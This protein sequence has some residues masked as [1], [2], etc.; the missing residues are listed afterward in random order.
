M[1]LP[2]YVTV[3][4]GPFNGPDDSDSAMQWVDITAWV[5]T[6]GGV[7]IPTSSFGRQ[8]DLSTVDPGQFT[9]ALNNQDHRFTPGNPSSPYSPGWRSGMRLRMVETVGFR[10]YLLAD[11]NMLQPAVTIQ[12]PDRFQ[13]VTV[14]AQDRIGR[15]QNSRKF[16]STLAEYIL[17]NGGS[18]LKAYYPCN[19]TGASFTDVSGNDQPPLRFRSDLP[20]GIATTSG[21]SL[22]LGG[23][24]APVFNDDGATI[25]MQA[26][27]G[28]TVAGLNGYS[29]VPDVAGLAYSLSIPA[30]QVMTLVTWFNASP[31]P[32]PRDM[33]AAG[34]YIKTT[35]EQI[36]TFLSSTNGLSV[37][38]SGS[39]SVGLTAIG[40]VPL[41]GWL[42][43]TIRY[44][45]SPQ[46][47]EA[48]I[49]TYR[50]AL[51]PSGSPPAS[52]QLVE[53]HLPALQCSIGH[54]QI[55][56]DTASTWDVPQLSAQIDAAK[57][58]LNGQYTGQR[59]ST[60][61]QY[62]G[63][64]TTELSQ[65][66]N[67]TSMMGPA[68]LAGKTAL[69]AAREAEETEQGLL[70]AYGRQLVYHDRNRRYNR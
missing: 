66:D 38:M 59:I 49:G 22:I 21:A 34:P 26:G 65:V 44:G 64:S 57:T 31:P 67:G 7:Q 18:S 25:S 51:S 11:G 45:W 46:V 16:I 13:T 40:Q 47:L 30:G 36:T 28:T 32:D 14:T 17:F 23:Q 20:G 52:D 39:T 53:M 50:V 4:A 6:A 41:T 55:Y 19:E 10:T 5:R 33:S 62:A 27:V 24:G 3:L 42:P 8:T 68:R 15:L 2:G 54:V 63:I 37:T 43:L 12:T 69:D 60:V 9:I 56:V 61:M 1:S 48:W 70:H 35:N 29:I 58:C